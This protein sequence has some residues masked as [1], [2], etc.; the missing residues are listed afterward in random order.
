MAHSGQII[1]EQLMTMFWVLVGY[2]MLSKALNSMSPAVLAIAQSFMIKAGAKIEITKPEMPKM[3]I[4][5]VE[6]S[7]I[8]PPK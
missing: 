4:S 2:Q 5:K 6:I 8:E 1:V 7:K 3:E